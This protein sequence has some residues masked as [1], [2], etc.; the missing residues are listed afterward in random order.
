M[1]LSQLLRILTTP[2]FANNLVPLIL[3]SIAILFLMGWFL[4][5]FLEDSDFWGLIKFVFLGI[6]FLYIWLRKYDD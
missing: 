4:F 2:R 1:S 5:D 3:I 6:Y